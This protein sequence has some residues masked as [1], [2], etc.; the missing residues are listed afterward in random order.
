MDHLAQAGGRAR[1]CNICNLTQR[2]ALQVGE[3]RDILSRHRYADAV[4]AFLGR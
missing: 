4:E 1:H 3:R 2:V